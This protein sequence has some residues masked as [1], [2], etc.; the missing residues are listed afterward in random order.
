M[1]Q[2]VNLVVGVW[3]QVSSGGW[4]FLED[5][6]ERKYAVMVHESQ[7]Y[8]TLMD[9][10]RTRYSVGVQTANLLT[11]EFPDWMKVPGGS[12]T[13]PGDVREDGDVELFMSIWLEI[14]ELRLLV[15]IGNDVV[16]R[17]LF[18]RRDNYTVIGSSTGGVVPKACTYRSHVPATNHSVGAWPHI[19][20]GLPDGTAYWEGMLAQGWVS[21][22]QQ[23]LMDLCTDEEMGVLPKNALSTTTPHGVLAQESSEATQSSTDSSTEPLHSIAPIDQMGVIRLD[24]A[25]QHLVC[26]PSMALTIVESQQRRVAILEYLRKRKGKV[27]V[28]MLMLTLNASITDYGDGSNQH[29]YVGQVFIDRSTFKTHMSLYALAKKFRF[30]CRRSEPGKMVL[31]CKGDRCNW[32][33]LASKLAGCSRFQIKVLSEHHTC[34]VDDRCDFKRHA[35]SNLIGEMV[36]SKFS[37]VEELIFK[38]FD[39]STGFVVRHINKA[40]YEVKGMDCVTFIVN[41]EQKNCSCLEFDMLLI[42]CVHASAAAIH[43]NR[44]V[45]S[46]VG[47]KYTRNICAA[48]Y[49]MSI[50]PKG[51]YKAHA[52]E[53]D[54]LGSLQLAPPKTRHPPRRPKKSRILSKGEFKFTRGGGL[55][56]KVRTCRRCGGTDHNRAT[57]KMPI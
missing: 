12:A 23:Y 45:D 27:A 39:V 32:R 13:P 50:N 30:Y 28:T 18:K 55:G 34:T 24:E 29:L 6:T 14:L 4:L 46:L 17:Y 10:V 44:R 16:A 52:P 41:L 33:V 36:R 43:S 40:E 57:C 26:R 3:E 25:N 1:G 5:P 11:Y 38:N 2:L 9:L 47:E 51:S 31:D 20:D 35:T 53:P 56:R 37:G 8:A 49:S 22:N 19:E 7:T 21:A 42:P 54:T 15:T 48:R